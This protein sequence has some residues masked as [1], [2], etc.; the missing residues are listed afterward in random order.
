MSCA[1]RL[2]GSVIES[3][4]RR[5]CQRPKQ[6]DEKLPHAS[7]CGTSLRPM[8]EGLTHQRDAMLESRDSGGMQIVVT[9]SGGLF[10]FY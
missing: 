9:T 8:L 6:D 7:P 10:A 1:C 2:I 3:D 4:D 5:G